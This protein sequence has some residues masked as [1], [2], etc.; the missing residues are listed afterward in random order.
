MVSFHSVSYANNESWGACPLTSRTPRC[1]RRLSRQTDAALRDLNERTNIM[2]NMA[3][4]TRSRAQAV[5]TGGLSDD[6][7]NVRAGASEFTI[8]G[9][10]STASGAD[11][12]ELL[13]ASL[14]ACTAMTLRFHALRRKY[15]LSRFE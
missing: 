12:Y 8:G 6:A 3:D 9:Q 5:V 1:R 10:S 4:I 14:A 13:S 7:F 11:P 15:P 2:A